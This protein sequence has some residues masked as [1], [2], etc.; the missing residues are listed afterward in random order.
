MEL[1][2]QDVLEPVMQ[3][4]PQDAEVSPPSSRPWRFKLILAAC[5]ASFLAAAAFLLPSASVPVAPLQPVATSPAAIPAIVP[6]HDWPALDAR[7]V[8]LL[9]TARL[10]QSVVLQRR[11]NAMG[12]VF[13]SRVE[14]DFLSWYL[15]FGR[16]KLEEL[17]AYNLHA[18]DTLMSLADGERHDSAQLKL[19]TTFESEFTQRVM[20]PDETRHT[21]LQLGQ[22]IADGY[23]N[24][25]SIGLREIQDAAGVPFAVWQA[26]LA[27]LPPLF[28]TT[29]SGERRMVRVDQLASP[30]PVWLELGREIGDA[31]MLRVDRMPSVI[32]LT[33]LVDKSGR[34]IFA[35]GENASIYFA[36][37][38]VYCFFMIL[39]F[40]SGLIPFNV[41]GFLLGW[42]LWETFSWG[43]WLGV[44]YLDFEKTRNALSPVIEART[45]THL[46]TLGAV[47]ADSGPGG[48]LRVL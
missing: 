28:Y 37:Y 32:D 11:V 19:I 27:Q 15:S 16:R 43:S 42:L 45:E 23:G 8:E 9:S 2:N 25:V 3:A 18:R 5:A 47:L 31:A 48:P 39:L 22:E 36:S 46:A 33:T 14:R 17:N 40:R 41:V 24:R 6:S 29:A 26:H 35:V 34:S 1:E 30:D 21:L 13:R 12:G 10:Q 44:E 4:Q 7:V 20:R 38:L